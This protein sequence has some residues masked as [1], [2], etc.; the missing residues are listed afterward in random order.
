M[1]TLLRA[2]L[3]SGVLIAPAFAEVANDA[4]VN[5]DDGERGVSVVSEYRAG[6][7]AVVIGGEAYRLSPEAAGSLAAQLRDR[8]G[9]GQRFGAGVVFG[10][11]SLG[12]PQITAIRV[13]P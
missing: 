9:G 11:D 1:L 12:R 3:C 13:F 6:E 5:G 4:L 7:G 2:A 10:R 8:R